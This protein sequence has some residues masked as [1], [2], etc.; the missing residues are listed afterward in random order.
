M[1]EDFLHHIWKFQKFSKTNLQTVT[2]ELVEIISP[3]SHNLNSGSDFFNAQIRIGGQIWAGNVEIH[4]NSSD[5]YAHRHETDPA[6]DA[7]ILHVVWNHDVEV[8][9]KDNTALP[10]L[11]LQDKIEETA[12]HSYFKLFSKNKKWINCEDS[13]A[14][15]DEFLLQNWLERLYFERLENKSDLIFRQLEKS[16]NDWEAVLFQLLAKN[17]GLKVNGDAFLSIA[18]S[19]DFS[20]MRKLRHKQEN[21]EALLFGQA[22]L[23]EEENTED[24]YYKNLR[25]DY[26]YIKTKFGLKN[27]EIIPVKFFRLRPVNFPTVRL[28]QLA[29]VYANEPQLF[30]KITEAKTKEEIEKLFAVSTTPF[31]DTH[32]NFKTVSAKR[33]KKISSAF[34]DLIIINTIA[35]IK[36][37]YAKAQGKDKTDEILTLLSS[38]P[39]EE[40]SIVQKFST[41]KPI[42]KNA[43]HSQALLE[44]KN[45]YCS[46]NR[47]LQ[48]AVGSSL[49]QDN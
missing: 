10:A 44:L 24:G 45:N 49:L 9:R 1:Q 25:A 4:V 13:F 2:G 42:A 23:L 7:V 11:T 19:F 37:C 30:S 12:L 34:V 14:E 32:Y 40:N 15:T 6:Y 38:I 21:L 26:A 16:K 39:K 28:A 17:F 46:P 8:Y 43:L 18:C 27:S 3:G 33:K 5:W 35:V 22:G 47:C 48:C 36:F 20:V 29:A 31:W 41:L